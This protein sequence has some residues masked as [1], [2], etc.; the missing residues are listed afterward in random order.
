M[1]DLIDRQAAINA[2]ENTECELTPKAWDE[3]TD[4]IM[5]VPSAQQWILCS[6]RM[7]NDDGEYL[8]CFEENYRQEYGFSEVGIAPFESDCESFGVWKYDGSDFYDI[9][10]VAWTELPKTY[11]GKYE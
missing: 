11:E 2:I 8:V 10:V 6:E 4:S 5:Q 9:P 1:S 3:L 7:P